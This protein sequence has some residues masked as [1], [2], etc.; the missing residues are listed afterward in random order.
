M[1]H[2]LFNQSAA[3]AI[4]MHSASLTTTSVL[5]DKNRAGQQWPQAVGE[6]KLPTS[7]QEVGKD[8]KEHEAVS[9][10]LHIR[11]STQGEVS[12]WN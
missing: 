12:S 2:V 6:G 8:A 9:P 5:L 11:A 1:A 10:I 4:G 7:T 3:V